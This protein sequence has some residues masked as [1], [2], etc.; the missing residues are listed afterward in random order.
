MKKKEKEQKR[1]FTTRE[2]AILMVAMLLVGIMIGSISS[3]AIKG[4]IIYN[5][6]STDYE[7]IIETYQNIKSEYYNDIDNKSLLDAA[8][9]GMI[10]SLDDEYSNFLDKTDTENLDKSLQDKYIGIGC[11]ILAKDNRFYVEEVY[12][13]TPAYEKLK[14]GDEI[15]KIDGKS[16]KGKTFSETCDLIA[17]RENTKVKITVLRDKKEKTYT[18]KRSKIDNPTVFS[19]KKNHV[20]IIRITSFTESTK[21]QFERELK[22]LEKENI[23]G[24][25]I[26]VRDNIGGYISSAGDIASMFLKKGTILYQLE[27]KNFT[28][29]V[30]DETKENRNI[31]VAVLINGSTASSAEVL[32]STLK[33]QYNATLIGEKTYGKGSVQKV[34]KL[35]SGA[36]YKVTIEKWKTS[37]GKTVEKKGLIPD[38][39]VSN[40]EEDRQL[41]KAL[42]IFK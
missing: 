20:G 22:E 36:S 35:S 15:I 41:E 10:E 31:K 16:I 24:L 37:Q 26:D 18:L 30:K 6:Y 2:V 14:K 39:T 21:K 17:G 28:S 27:K 5:K 7:E 12:K 34:V 38:I 19:D 3:Y 23:K 13:E 9:K 33:E 32:A 29:K 8:V 11:G 4:T 40:D 25:I 42:Q 1:G